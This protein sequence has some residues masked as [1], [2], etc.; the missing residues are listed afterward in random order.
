M[1][2]AQSVV[3]ILLQKLVNTLIQ[4]AL[5]LYGVRDQVE[6]VVFEF[7]RMVAFLEDA[8]SMQE[9]N[10]RVKK[11]VQH[12]RDAAYVA[13]DVI[14]TFIL[15][16]ATSK[17]RK[18]L[19]CIKR[20]ACIP[21]ELKALHD[22]GSEIQRIN[23]KIHRISES[24]STYG[25]VDIG[26]GAGKSSADPILE[27]RRLASPDF[28][29][30]D[31]V[32]FQKDS[33]AL[34]KKLTNESEQRRCVVSVVGMGGLGKTTLTKK[35]YNDPRLKAHFDSCAWISISQEYGV[36][37]LLQK[38]LNCYF[39]KDKL[40][41]VEK[42]DVNQ[43]RREIS[44]H[45]EKKRYLI[46]L[47]DIWSK[48]AWNDLK[49]AFS[50]MNNGSRVVLTTRKEEVALYAQS[51][52]HKPKLLNDKEDW[53]LFCKKT[54]ADG[55]CPGDLVGVGK[56]IVKKCGGLP[57]AVVVI[58]GLLRTKTKESEEWEKVHQSISWHLVKG[59]FNISGILSLSY[60]DLPYYL[61]PCFLYLGNFPEDYEF[62][63]KKL[64]QMWAAEGFLEER[65]EETLEEVGEDYLMELIQRSMVQVTERS[66]SRGIKK[67]RIHDLLRDLS[68]SEAKEGM[69]LQVHSRINANAPPASR[70]RRLAIHHN[71]IS[72]YI[73]LSSSTRRL[74]SVLMYAQGYVDL[75]RKEAK[76]LF[77]SCKLLRVLCLDSVIIKK[78]PREIGE[79]IHLRY[80][81]CTQTYL[82]SLPSSIGN[83]PN[84]QTLFVASHYDIKVPSTIG[85]MQQLRHLQLKNNEEGGGVIEGQPRLERISNL[86]TL[87]R[88]MAGKWMEGCLENLTNLRKLGIVIVTTADAEVFK[89]SIVKLGYLH[90]LSVSVRDIRLLVPRNSHLVKLRRSEQFKTQEWSLPPFSNLLKLSKLYRKVRE[91]TRVC[92]IPSK[93]HQAYL[94][95]LR[96]KARPI[97]D[98]REAA[99]TPH[100]QIAGISVQG[101]GNGLLFTRVSSA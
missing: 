11:W 83:L 60:K 5:F 97:G 78:L 92:S 74:R 23:N 64:I 95:L 35:V 19:G 101:K 21:V 65:G 40:K 29:E 91:V 66:S 18:F 73:S 94:E 96:F 68:I 38:I 24:R 56:E 45:L 75:Q 7:E 20:Y 55:G 34:V 67:C 26:Q 31:Y 2:L 9:G 27:E 90:S 59:E 13:E 12:V 10:K 37:D 69:F 33:D 52:L 1:D 17:R 4:E 30:A 22:V 32:G 36:A 61:K 3:E 6:L 43:L 71:D 49:D 25:I 76:F 15:K 99:K 28:E 47:D 80:L 77:R 88:V 79:L 50:E 42:M 81:G 53:E 14:D 87:S 48:E 100:S 63:A 93:P 41:E 57:L 46:V 16:I 51:E 86:Q 98:F 62:H 8:D 54:F 72:K 84:L 82:K 89:D 70:A 44:K 58:S 39:S 85:K